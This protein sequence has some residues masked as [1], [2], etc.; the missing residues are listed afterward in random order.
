[1]NKPRITIGLAT[2][3]DFEGVWATVQSVFL[4]NEWESPDD[5]QIVIVDTSPMGSEHRQLVQDYVGKGGNEKRSSRTQNIRYVDMAGFAGTTTPRDVIFRFADADVVCVM[6]CHVMLPINRLLRLVQWFDRHP[7]CKDLIHGPMLHDNLDA[8]STHFADQ[9]RGG[10]WGTWGTAWQTPDGK[11]FVCEGEEVTDENRERKSDGLVHYHDLMTLEPID[12]GL[13]ADIPWAGHDRKLE[14]LGCVQLGKSES[15]KPFEIPG[16]GMGL[17]SCRKDAWLGFAKNCTG[18]GGEEMNIH[19]KYRQAGH[20]ALCLPFLKW[21]HRFGRAGGA[22]Y[23]IPL[24]AKI[25]NYV[26]WAKELN[27][28]LDRIHTHFVKS[29]Q[30]P[31]DRWEA[32]IADPVKF[33]VELKAQPKQSGQGAL[34]FVFFQTAMTARDLKEHAEKIKSYASRVNSITAFVK[35]A[36]WEPMLA[37]GFP[38]KLDVYQSEESPLIL[39]THEA[40]KA[41]DSKDSRKIEVYN[42]HHKDAAVDPLEVDAIEPCEMLV[43][44]KVNSSEYLGQ[45]LAKHG[46]Q[47]TA[48]IMIRGTQSFGE[49]AEDD[50]SKPGMFYA[51]KAFLSENPEW[52]VQAHWPNQYGLTVLAKDP[53]PRPEREITPWPKGYGPGTELKAILGSVGIN[54]SPTCSCNAYMR[55]MDEWG[56]V[57]CVEHFDEISQRLR[58][59]AAEWGWDK[60]VNKE[61]DTDE[62][63]QLRLADKLKIGIKS[64]TTGLAFKVNWLDPFGGLVTEAI[65]HAEAKEKDKCTKDCDPESCSKPGC[66]RKAAVAV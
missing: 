34:D 38:A 20:K 36:D 11:I 51:I 15:N 33:H 65:R 53:I 57:G 3:D 6:D 25:R 58:E 46:N 23:P 37:A 44:D 47:A 61:A 2:C 8:I 39:Q 32:L 30:F 22:P 5:V 45:V 21:N 26:L 50:S 64:I 17:F 16:C 13:P 66:K 40:V 62:V 48:L 56:V 55:Q 18:F 63:H 35:R 29:G 52:F 9:F 42:T 43:I 49:R 27:L 31:V 14:S 10:M 24:A 1:L 41:Q 19:T 4:N 54:P 7:D 60:L 28:P 12:V 59:K